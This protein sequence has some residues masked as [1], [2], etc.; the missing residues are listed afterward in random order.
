MIKTNYLPIRQG[1]FTYGKTFMFV[2]KMLMVL[3]PAAMER[4]VKKKKE[5][6]DCLINP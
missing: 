4:I 3:L 2:N 6:P 1:V 5:T